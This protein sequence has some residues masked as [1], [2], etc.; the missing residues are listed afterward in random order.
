MTCPPPHHPS[1]ASAANSL[2]TGGKDSVFKLQAELTHRGTCV[3]SGQCVFVSVSVK[4][5]TKSVNQHPALSG[6]PS[7]F[8]CLRGTQTVVTILRIKV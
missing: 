3:E 8:V 2:E 1:D 7:S 6:K 4:S 5:T